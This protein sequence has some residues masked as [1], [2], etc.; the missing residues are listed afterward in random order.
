[1]TSKIKQKYK[2]KAISSFKTKKNLF[3]FHL[4]IN[5]KTTFRQI[6]FQSFKINE[7]IVKAYTSEYW[8][9]EKDYL[10]NGTSIREIEKRTQ[11]IEEKAKS[12]ITSLQ[13]KYIDNFEEI[14]PINQFKKLLEVEHCFYCGITENKIAKLADSHKLYKKS[15]RGWSLEIERLNSNYE[16]SPKNCELACYWCNNAKTDEFTPDEF[17]KVAK[18]I[19]TIWE[20]RL[21]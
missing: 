8:Q 11:Q 13:Q 9:Q 19:K 10:I 5:G 4:A 1:M 18:A 6:D 20:A 15:F 7:K 17:T 16:Y 2:D 12:F 14:Y 3:F 21:K